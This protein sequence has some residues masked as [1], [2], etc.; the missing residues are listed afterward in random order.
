MK[1]LYNKALVYQAFYNAR[2]PLLAGGL[3]IGFITY[4]INVNTIGSLRNDISTLASDTVYGI[5]FLFI[6]AL[7]G[8]LFVIYVTIT[9]FNKRNTIMFLNSGPFT[10][11]SIKKNELLLLFGSLLLL[12]SI[13]IY[14]S[15][16]MIFSQRELF[17]I[18]SYLYPT[19]IF[20]LL[21]IFLVGTA[22]ICYLEF[23]DML[24][25]NTFM[26]I[27]AMGAAPIT[28]YYIMCFI[29]YI[30]STIPYKFSYASI[31]SSE[32]Y[33]NSIGIFMF[34]QKPFKDYFINNYI[35]IFITLIICIIILLF[36]I[37]YLNKRSSIEK[38]NKFFI[39]PIVEKITFSIVSFCVALP[40]IAFIAKLYEE[41]VLLDGTNN[42]QYI[43]S[44][45]NIKATLYL[46]VYVVIAILLAFIINKI[47][48]KIIKRFI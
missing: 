36:T 17:S 47:L 11:E 48:K 9:G 42:Y 21:K 12:I 30:S 39:F 44:V 4:I 28:V 37:F 2:W 31:D 32:N 13:Y 14:I 19:L 26:T 10:K 27:I 3:F 24:F 43:I 29:M 23:W 46:G 1:K 5:D 33:M 25:S 18:S 41:F 20:N 22:F 45:D 34:Q 35:L 38:M 15:V 8:V 40:I 16:C 7:C 6:L